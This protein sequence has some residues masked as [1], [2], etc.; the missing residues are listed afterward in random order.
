MDHRGTMASLTPQIGLQRPSSTFAGERPVR[1]PSRR[2]GAK[3]YRFWLG[4]RVPGF[5]HEGPSMGATL[6][7]K[8]YTQASGCGHET[9]LCKSS[10]LP[11]VDQSGWS[12]GSMGHMLGS[13]V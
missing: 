8:H 3:E 13:Q 1:M 5:E 7:H 11:R 2:S 6:N 12:P 9:W 4:A 10:G